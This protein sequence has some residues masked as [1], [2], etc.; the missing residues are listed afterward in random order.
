MRIANMKNELN[1]TVEDTDPHIIGMTESWANKDVS[2]AALGYV[3]FRR[4][5]IERKGG[6]VILYIKESIQAYEIK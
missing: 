4:D 1:I 2:D 6:E 3:M 5:R